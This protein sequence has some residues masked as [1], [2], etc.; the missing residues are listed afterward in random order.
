MLKKVI[1]SRIQS[2]S[3]INTYK[4]CPRKYYYNYIKKLPTQP[5]IHLIRGKVAH[6]V[7]E[8]FFDINISIITK[9]TMN[10][11]L[12]QRTLT[13]L[14]QY[15]T[16]SDK[17]LNKLNLTPTEIQHYFE[18]TLIML[19]HWTNHIIERINQ[20]N[21]PFTEAFKNITPSR[22]E[23][24]MC[25]EFAIR[26]FIDAIETVNNKIRIIDY[27]TSRQAKISDPYK[28]QLAIYSLLYKQKHGVLPHKVGIFFLKHKLPQFINVTPELVSH[29]KFEIEQIHMNTQSK[30]ITDYP[31][32][33]G[34]LCKWKTGQCDFYDTCFNQKNLHE[35]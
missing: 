23:A 32:K 26:G 4:Q 21:L 10:K 30:N 18:E 8:H 14:I 5:S 29:A 16:Q 6:S 12:H 20:S 2:P 22:E 11:I 34:P 33:V 35:F 27:K 15:W 3:S 7:L 31:K 25:K 13:L 17:N 1:P 9:K 19:S 28:L 24:F